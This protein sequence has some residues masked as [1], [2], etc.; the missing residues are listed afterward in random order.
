MA[1]VATED[2]VGCFRPTGSQFEVSGESLLFQTPTSAQGVRR[3]KAA[4]FQ[5]V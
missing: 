5:W 3:D 2:T 1:D 4:L